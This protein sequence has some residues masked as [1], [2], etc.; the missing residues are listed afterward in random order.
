MALDYGYECQIAPQGTLIA[1]VDEVG[2]GALAGPV[3]AAAVIL[4]PNR[5]PYGLDDS[6]RLSPARRAA[7]FDIILR[8]AL[9]VALAAIP[10][11]MIDTLNIRHASLLAM[12]RAVGGLVLAPDL[13]LV[14]GRDLPT[15]LDRPALAIIGGDGKAAS[16]AAASIIAKV[17]RDRQ[18]QRLALAF[19]QYGFE[20]HVGYGTRLHQEMLSQHGITVLHR[21]TFMNG[22]S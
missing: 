9:G 14:D 22:R 5:V 7:L 12:T 16:I 11:S 13:V 4:D 6:K 17:S 8:D 1:G 10:A 21:R 19:P 18:M 3:V 2:R 15:S 20:R